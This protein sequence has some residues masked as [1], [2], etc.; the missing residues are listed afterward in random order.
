MSNA[1]VRLNN[2]FNNLPSVFDE[3]LWEVDFPN[4]YSKVLNGRC[5]FEEDNEK[6]KVMLEV[7]G[8]KKDEININLKND[9]LT[10]SWKRE[11]EKNEDTKKRAVYE[12][13]SGSFT[14]NFYVENA[15]ADKVEAEL[16]DG[17]LTLTLHKK[18]SA[19]PREIAIK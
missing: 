1:L 13:S 19:K 10:I 17:I 14:R 3:D 15:D 18:E 4:E 6:Y 11:R 5:D 2:I 7:P 8:V 9:N 16:K 12:R